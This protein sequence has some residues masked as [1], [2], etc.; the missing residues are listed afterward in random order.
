MVGV[1][2]RI[3]ASGD[4]LLVSWCHLVHCPRPSVTMMWIKCCNDVDSVMFS[5]TL[6]SRPSLM[7]L[8]VEILY[9]KLKILFEL[10]FPF[11]ASLDMFLHAEVTSL[12]RKLDT[13]GHQLSSAEQICCE[14][15]SRESDLQET[16]TAK[17]TQLDVLRMRLNEADRLLELEKQRIT[18]LHSERDR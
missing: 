1:V 18:D 16:L 8:E 3:G 9:K 2:G 17:E 5:R 10:C 6:C 13:Q 12:Q 4:C 7:Q 14:L 15:R 11:L